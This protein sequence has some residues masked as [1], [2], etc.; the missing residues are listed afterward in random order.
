M[1]TSFG[2]NDARTC[3]ECKNPMRLTRRMPHPKY[4]YDFELQKFTCEV[5]QHETKR[6]ADR[7]GAVTPRSSQKQHGRRS[8]LLRRYRA[9]KTV[10]DRTARLRIL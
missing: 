2:T 5:C 3:P 1:P 10:S 7:P 8:G 6:N 9:M 4:G